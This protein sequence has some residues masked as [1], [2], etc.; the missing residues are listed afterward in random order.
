MHNISTKLLNY[1]IIKPNLKISGINGKITFFQ[2]RTRNA[3]FI[4]ISLRNNMFDLADR[5]VCIHKTQDCSKAI[6][7]NNTCTLGRAPRIDNASMDKQML[8]TQTQTQTQ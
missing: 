7:I 8:L 5:Y 3:Q 4:I 1:S 2:D 6:T